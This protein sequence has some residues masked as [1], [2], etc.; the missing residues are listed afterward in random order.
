MTEMASWMWNNR[1]QSFIVGGDF[2]SSPYSR[3]ATKVAPVADSAWDLAGEGYGHTFPNGVNPLPPIRID[4]IY[5]SKD[6]TA[7]KIRLGHGLGSD[8]KPLFA[9]IARRA[10]T[11]KESK[12]IPG[13][14]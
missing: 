3:F 7:L 2:N 9:R 6:L 5:L 10:V 1:E 8:H 12:Y 11:V 13:R 14:F 4:H